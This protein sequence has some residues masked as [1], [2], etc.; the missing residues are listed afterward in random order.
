MLN[1]LSFFYLYKFEFVNFFVL[2]LIER[3]LCSFYVC[4][5]AL[6]LISIKFL[7]RR[8][9]SLEKYLLVP[10]SR[11]DTVCISDSENVETIQ[12]QGGLNCW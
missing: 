1:N 5:T 2:P 3:F 7:L 12:V 9:L 11:V 4:L 8:I 6:F 10:F